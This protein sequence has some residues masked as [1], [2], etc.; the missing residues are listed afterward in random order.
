MT[1]PLPPAIDAEER[2]L[3]LPDIGRLMCYAD[4]SG[5]GLPVLLVHSINAAPSAMEVRPLFEHLRGRRPV[6]AI[7]LPGFGRSERRDRDYSPEFF[8]AALLAVVRALALDQVHGLALSTSCEFLARAANT[9]PA[10]FASLVM[11]SPTGLQ[12]RSPPSPRTRER[13]HGVFRTPLVGSTLYRLLRTRPSV[14]YFL[15]MAFDDAPPQDLVD[16]ACATTAQPGAT[17]A[18]FH[19]LSGKLFSDD[20]VAELYRPLSQPTLMLYD[21]DPNVGFDRLQELLAANTHWRAQRIPGTKGLPHW[22]Q[23]AA[24]FAALDAFWS[25]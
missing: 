6:Y 9:E 15:G 13:I 3:Q 12:H 17:H 25:D 20:A 18:P 23:P 1:A 16:Y 2:L 14:R 22:D 21:R 10:A 4:T 11:V 19:F 7:D 5:S 8:S 24:T